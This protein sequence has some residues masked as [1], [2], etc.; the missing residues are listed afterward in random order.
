MLLIPGMRCSPNYPFVFC[1]IRLLLA[2]ESHGALPQHILDKCQL[3][4]TSGGDLSIHM[5]AQ[6]HACLSSAVAFCGDPS[7][8]H[9]QHFSAVTGEAMALLAVF[10]E[11]LPDQFIACQSISMLDGKTRMPDDT[12]EA[13]KVPSIP[14][15]HCH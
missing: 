6:Y 9:G 10:M 1:V 14:D 4:P 15:P 3:Y 2:G 8:A 5:Q 13:V 12:F 7:S 11:C